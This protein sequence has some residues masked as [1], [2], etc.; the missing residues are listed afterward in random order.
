ME[1]PQ[2][3]LEKVR[4]YFYNKQGYMASDEVCIRYWIDSHAD[5]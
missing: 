2:E 4:M 3:F 5:V 1:Y